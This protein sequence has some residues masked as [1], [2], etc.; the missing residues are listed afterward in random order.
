MPV[1]SLDMRGRADMPDLATVL[2]HINTT[3]YLF[4]D[5]AEKPSKRNRYSQPYLR[6]DTT[7]DKFPILVRR[8]E[9]GSVQLSSD[10]TALD[11]ATSQSTEPDAQPNDWPSFNKNRHSQQSLPLNALRRLS[12]TEDFSQ[13]SSILQPNGISSDSIVKLGAANRRSMEVKFSPFADR[14]SSII[15]GPVNGTANGV[16]KLQS[17]YST[18]DIPTVKNPNGSSTMNSGA[19][20]SRAEQRLHNHNASLGRIPPGAF[21]N[22]QGRE[23][24]INETRLEE[25]ANTLRVLNSALQPSAPAFGPSIAATIAS[26]DAFTNN[27]QSTTTAAGI[28]SL[29]NPNY[30]GPLGMQMLNMDMTSMQIGGPQWNNHMA[31]LY[32]SQ[33]PPYPQSYQHY[34][35]GRQHEAQ[36]RTIN[37]RRV[38]A[39]GQNRPPAHECQESTAN[40]SAETARWANARL[41]DLRPEIYGMCKDQHGCRFLQRALE[42]RNPDHIQL[43]FEETNEHAIELMTGILS[44]ELMSLQPRLYANNFLDPFGNYLCQKLLEYANDEQRT[45]LINNA[46]PQMVKIAFNQHGT[47]A[48]QKM[49]DFIS[50]SEQVCASDFFW[51][52]GI[53]R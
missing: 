41:E 18:S 19:P 46:A 30:Y 7:E 38:P 17:S 14:R 11:L 40:L 4:G 24:S 20:K 53:M 32:Q 8:E 29:T 37:Q 34:G 48:L 35:T 47:R 52:Y 21:P 51:L 43:I 25:Q 44:A 22:R 27:A 16:P 12:Q 15:G 23:I 2:G 5:E 3:E 36:P 50:T 42:E 49:I 31:A 10:S 45:S 9:D 39:D 26:A 1:T 28:P 13:D 33:Y 6:M